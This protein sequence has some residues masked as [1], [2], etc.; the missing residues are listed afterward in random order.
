MFDPID[1]DL[2]REDLAKVEG[3]KA[4]SSAAKRSS[5]GEGSGSEVETDRE[6]LTQFE[7]LLELQMADR[8]RILLKLAS[9]D[10]L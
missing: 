7:R 5:L 10:V 2:A 8:D 1:R 3:R 6:L 4:G 9:Y